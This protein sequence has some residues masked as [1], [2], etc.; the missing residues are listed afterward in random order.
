M[1]GKASGCDYEGY[2]VK[3]AEPQDTLP[4]FCD[5]PSSTSEREPIIADRSTL[6]NYATCPFMARAIDDGRVLDTTLAALSGQV[7][8]DAISAALTMYIECDG[9]VPTSALADEVISQANNSR[10]DVQPDVVKALKYFAW[11]W[12]K[13]LT[14]SDYGV[15]PSSIQYYD[16][17]PRHVQPA[18]DYTFGDDIVRATSEIDILYAGPAK[19]VLHERDWKSG[20]THWTAAGVADAFQ[21]QMHAVL[22]FEVYPD[23]ECL[24]VTIWNTRSNS[25][26]YTVEFPR[27]KLPQYNA[28]VRSA[29]AE[30]YQW[31]TSESQPTWPAVEKCS[32][33]RAASICPEVRETTLV[34]CE[35]DPGR[36]V[37]RIAATESCFQQMLGFARDYIKCNDGKDIVSSSGTAFGTHKPKKKT[38]P[39]Y[40]IYSVPKGNSDAP[41]DEQGG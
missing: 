5:V 1:E 33:C 35:Q 31:R 19:K 9:A 28:R 11:P 17:D 8:H 32:R 12:A 40:E 15:H 34:E 25:T 6:E 29:A 23:C 39:K 20:N 16:G 21:F 27:E 3:K 26:S 41:S 36:F 24:E 18:K 4:A 10:P 38:Y 7:A 14:N 22:V 13:W 2:K 30:F 37:D